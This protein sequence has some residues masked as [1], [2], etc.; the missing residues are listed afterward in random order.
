LEARGGIEPPVKVL[1]T[2]ALPLGDRAVTVHP[3]KKTQPPNFS[4][5]AI[6]DSIVIPVWLRTLGVRFAALSR[7]R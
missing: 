4:I 3:T 2:F 6:T 1:Q 5:F 7:F